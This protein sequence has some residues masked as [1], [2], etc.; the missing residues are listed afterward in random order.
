MQIALGRS[1]PPSGAT[2]ASKTLARF[3][4]QRSLGRPL[5]ELPYIAQQCTTQTRKTPA[6]LRGFHFKQLIGLIEHLPEYGSIPSE[7][8]V[9]D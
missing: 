3:I 5:H 7:S 1:S 9:T 2:A 4:E 8:F 6:S